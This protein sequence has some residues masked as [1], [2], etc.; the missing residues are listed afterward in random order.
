MSLLFAFLL[1]AQAQSPAVAAT[2]KAKPEAPK[3]ICE[4]TQV[5]GSHTMRRICH[6]KD[7]NYDPMTGPGVGQFRPVNADGVSGLKNSKGSIPTG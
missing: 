6:D 5:T 4:R 7:G 2:E 3:M 1:A